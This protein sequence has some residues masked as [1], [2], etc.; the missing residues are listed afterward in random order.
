[1]DSPPSTYHLYSLGQNEKTL[2]K[3]SFLG[4]FGKNGIELH[5]FQHIE[6]TRVVN[7]TPIQLGEEVIALHL[8]EVASFGPSEATRLRQGSGVVGRLTI[9]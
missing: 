7:V 1:M 3:H 9:I 8:P 6:K 4:G 2:G 5:S